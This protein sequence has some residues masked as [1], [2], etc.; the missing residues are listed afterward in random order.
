MKRKLAGGS[1]PSS[2]KPRLRIKNASEFRP[3]KIHPAR[4]DEWQLVADAENNGNYSPNMRGGV[5]CQIRT[6]RKRGY[7]NR[8]R[9][10][11]PIPRLGLQ[12]NTQ[13]SFLDGNPH[14]AIVKY[15]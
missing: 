11:T 9:S 8:S 14:G 15:Q 5:E 13:T 6:V 2:L 12:N 10:H 1:R 7:D 3:N 4:Q